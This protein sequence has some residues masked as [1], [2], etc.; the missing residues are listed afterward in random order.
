MVLI[1]EGLGHPAAGDGDDG[2]PGG[3]NAPRRCGVPRV[4]QDQR[5]IS[6]V[7]SPQ[8]IASFLKNFLRY[9]MRTLES[10]SGMRPS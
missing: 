7:E 4:R 6:D 9:E 3:D 10:S 2:E 8:P 1:A 5:R